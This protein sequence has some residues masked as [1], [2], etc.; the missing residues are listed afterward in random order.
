L[1]LLVDWY[2]TKGFPEGHI[3]SMFRVEV[4]QVGKVA[5]YVKEQQNKW[6]WYKKNPCRLIR[7]SRKW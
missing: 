5:G 6:L 1:W 2:E 4:G 3:A 7:S